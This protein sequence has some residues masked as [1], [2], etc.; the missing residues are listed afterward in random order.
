MNLLL[1]GRITM[2][3]AIYNYRESQLPA[4]RLPKEWDKLSVEFEATLTA[5]Q[6]QMFHRLSDLQCTA[7]ADELET[8]Y[9]IGFKDVLY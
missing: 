7:T 9:K 4:A 2:I 3:D 1:K 5:E 6:L 8:A